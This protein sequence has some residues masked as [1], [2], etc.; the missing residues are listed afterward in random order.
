MTS[1]TN[2]NNNSNNININNNTSYLRF[3][4]VDQVST[5]RGSDE[6]QRVLQ[7][8][9]SYD[10]APPTAAK[11]MLRSDPEYSFILEC[12]NVCVRIEQEKLKIHKFIVDHYARRFP[13]LVVLVQDA[14]TYARVVSILGNNIFEMDRFMEQLEEWIP[15]QLLAALVASTVTTRGQELPE[16]DMQNI[17][18]AC[19]ELT[20]LEEVK[21]V[22][23]EYIQVKMI[24]V[25]RN[26]CAFL[27]PGIASQLVATAG[28]VDDLALLTNEELI[29]LGSVRAQKIGFAIKTA[30]FLNN[31]DLVQKQPAELRTKAL[32][33]VADQVSRLAKLDAKREGA[34]ESQGLQGRDFVIRK[35]LEWTD[36]LIQEER[37]KKHGLS[38][39]LY[40]RRTRV[41]KADRWAQAAANTKSFQ[42]QQTVASGTRRQRG[43]F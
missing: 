5:Y 29:A 21:Q 26:I 32:R 14:T 41:N 38:N 28:S 24:Y 17:L 20:S 19:K 22:L 35:I 27:G 2:S 36:P 16:G 30:G 13:E 1:S 18:A 34:D 33:L 4:T 42:N 43:E 37:R 10:S 15:S 6:L 23:L 12:G 31:T 3:A 25:C 39:K 7:D 11:V 8:L 40:E 9:Q